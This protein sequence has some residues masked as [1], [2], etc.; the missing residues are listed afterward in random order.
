MVPADGYEPHPI[1]KGFDFQTFFPL[2][3]SLDLASPAPAGVT[4]QALRENHTAFLGGDG[5]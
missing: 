5:V 4:L 2:A 1:T 3:S